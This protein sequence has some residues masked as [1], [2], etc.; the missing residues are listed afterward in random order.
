MRGWAGGVVLRDSGLNQ[1]CTSMNKYSAPAG[2]DLK[3]GV[4]YDP[5]RKYMILL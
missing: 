1:R 5:K 3:L 4:F 2:N